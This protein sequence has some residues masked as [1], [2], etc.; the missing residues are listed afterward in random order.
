MDSFYE[1]LKLASFNVIYF[2]YDSYLSNN[3]LNSLFSI[4]QV[5]QNLS[6]T[7]CDGVIFL[8]KFI[9][10]YQFGKE[11]KF[12]KKYLSLFNILES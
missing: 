11:E 3:I 6:M 12:M 9:S 4:I 10:S 5:I 8:Y 2:T 7:I 1:N